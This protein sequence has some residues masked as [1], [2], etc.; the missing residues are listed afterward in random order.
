MNSSVTFNP[1]ASSGQQK[2]GFELLP[3]LAKNSYSRIVCWIWATF[4]YC[5]RNYRHDSGQNYTVT[6]WKRLQKLLA[7]ALKKESD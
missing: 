5:G 6:L 1:V 4:L 2:F 3:K 7:Q